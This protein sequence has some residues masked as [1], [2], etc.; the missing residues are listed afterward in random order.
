M[1]KETLIFLLLMALGGMLR[2]WALGADPSIL[3]DSGQV[4]DEGYWLYNA[5]NL[6]LFGTTVPDQFYHDFAAAPLFSLASYLSFL[7]FGVGFWQARLVSAA[8]GVA[9]LFFTYKIGQK[10]NQKVAVLSTFFVAINTMLILHNRLAVGESLSIM[11]ATAGVS[12]LFLNKKTEVFSGASFALSLLSKTTSFL[13]LPSAVLMILSDMRNMFDVKRLVYFCISLVVLF[14]SIFGI[15]YFKWGNEISLIY[16]TFG[17]WYAPKTILGIWQNILNFVLHPFWG[18][19]FLFSIVILASLNSLN[20]LFDR[21]SRTRERRLLILWVLGFF[22][23]GPFISGLSN[24]RLL[25]LIVPI[26]ILGAQT[27]FSP[28]Y[29]QLKFTKTAESLTKLKG[30]AA[31]AAGII[32]GAIP[33]VIAGKILLAILKRVSGELTVVNNLPYISLIVLFITTLLALKKRAIL[34][35]LLA[36]DV[37]VLIFLPI[38][39]FIPLFWGYLNFFGV[40]P[41]PQTTVISLLSAISFI[42]FWVLMSHLSNLKMI[43]LPLVA[44]YII[45]NL[46]GI[47]TIIYKPTYNIESAAQRVGT[48]VGEQGFIGFWGHELSINNRSWPIY[49]APRLSG[50]GGMNTN[51][52]D[53]NPRFLLLTTVF[54]SKVGTRGDW[55]EI[56]DV[57]KPLT[58]IERLDLSRKF[59]NS[60]RE[61]KVDVYSIG[62]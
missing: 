49:W 28:A 10:I 50:V 21:K 11:F 55:P 23:L 60:Q 41:P 7:T 27:V 20:F 25:G 5:R 31:V 18:S 38:A 2:F 24:A 19:P 61:F 39:A 35:N 54:D 12:F 3:L 17:T 37:Y 1:K 43:A 26:A 4:G 16:S 56:G 42:A 29:T 22:A 34:K 9:I 45:F 30:S 6:A 48:I 13:Y 15:L 32:L 14:S 57:D 36:L 46:A 44:I 47:A 51:W 8:S 33:A 62:N 53:Y 40:A 58:H 59:L 52:Q